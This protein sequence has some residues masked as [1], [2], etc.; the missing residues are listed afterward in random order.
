M[1]TGLQYHSCCLCGEGNV[2]TLIFGGDYS[3]MRC[4]RMVM[5]AHI[6]LYKNTLLAERN[7][8][9]ECRESL[10]SEEE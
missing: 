3:C 1:E 9:K 2:L 4:T 10:N 6:T 7:S 5:K 8:N